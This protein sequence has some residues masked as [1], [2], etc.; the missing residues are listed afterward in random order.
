MNKSAGMSFAC[1]LWGAREAA[2]GFLLALQE[3]LR[4]AF[5]SLG[6]RGFRE[7]FFE[8]K[9]AEGKGRAGIYKP[10]LLLGLG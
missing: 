10:P 7:I 8:F 2:F 3:N 5:K 1:S 9:K 4:R 6:S